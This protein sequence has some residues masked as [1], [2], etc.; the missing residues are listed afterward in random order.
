MTSD[1][2]DV[3]TETVSVAAGT[4]VLTSAQPNSGAGGAAITYNGYNLGQVQGAAF[5]D[6]ANNTN[7][8]P[9]A[10]LGGGASATSVVPSGMTAGIGSTW[11]LGSNGQSNSVPFTF[12]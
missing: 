7:V 11:L 6:S 3:E 9:A 2:S 8:V 1:A 10:A 5:K 12:G 4:M